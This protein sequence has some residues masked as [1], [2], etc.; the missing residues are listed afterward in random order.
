[1][2]FWFLEPS[3]DGREASVLGQSYAR[4][5]ALVRH[6]G[7]QKGSTN[8]HQLIPR[9]KAFDDLILLVFAPCGDPAAA[10]NP[11]GLS[12]HGPMS[13]VS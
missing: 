3:L 4:V 7:A 6:Q 12:M 2:G 1:M 5:D 10:Q 11:W 9:G 13:K 8:I